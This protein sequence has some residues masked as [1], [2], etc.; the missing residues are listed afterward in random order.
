MVNQMMDI[1]RKYMWLSIFVCALFFGLPEIIEAHP[2]VGIHILDPSEIDEAAEHFVPSP[3]KQVFV[4]VPIRVDQLNHQQWQTFF[5]KVEEYQL[6]PIIR[7][8][9]EYDQELEAWRRPTRADIVRFAQ[10]FAAMPWYG[11]RYIVIFNEPNHAKEWGGQIDVESYNEI[12]AFAADW[13]HTDHF[14][15]K[16]LPGGLDAAAPNGAETMDSFDFID[17]MVIDDPDILTKIDVWN[18]HAYPNPAFSSSAYRSAKN[19][20]DG[21]KYEVAYLRENY[22]IDL[23]VFITETGWD[24]RQFSQ[25][26]LT[27][28]YE[29]ALTNVWNDSKVKAV[30]PFILKGNNGIFDHFSFLMPDGQP[31]RQMKALLAAK[32]K[33]EI[34][35]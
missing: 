26:Q 32:E 20:I 34:N 5:R 1:I 10:F 3:Q 33:L 4:T 28:Y 21:W 7:L 27:D 9:T 17:K 19:A 12:L 23:D 24:Q 35:L 2:N 22:Q 25:W 31:S 29:H 11:D 13:F 18:S 15:Y 6:I 8:A 30:T 14:S 16:V